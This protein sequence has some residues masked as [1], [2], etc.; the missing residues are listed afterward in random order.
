MSFHLR[1]VLA[2]AFVLIATIPVLFLGIWVEET[3]MEREIATVAEKHLLRA[4]NLSSALDR[5]AE[6]SKA[7]FEFLTAKV[8]TLGSSPTSVELA[9]EFGF[10]HICLVDDSGLVSARWG[11]AEG[12]GMRVPQATMDRLLLV[13]SP[14]SAF[15]DVM[16][17]G[18]GQ[19]TIFLTRRLASGQIAVA[20]LSLDY[21]RS[22]QKEISFG[23]KGHSAVFD[24]SGNFIA[25]PKLDGQR[26]IRNL[27][28][29]L[30]VSMMMAGNTGITTFFSPAIGQDHD[31][32]IYHRRKHGLGC[33][34]AAAP[35]G[36]RGP[37]QLGP[38][39]G[40]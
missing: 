18:A 25:H 23:H 22:V 17:D 3:A 24:G 13:T 11:T 33:H 16:P 10:R 26:E 34:G 30:P 27:A 14:V 39:V 21:I 40:I 15:S 7:V 4:R 31:Y 2:L 1:H 36:T 5:Y 38:G 37:R 32:R 8:E 19:P 12:F 28:K 20:T 35:A 9:R 29:V 6:N